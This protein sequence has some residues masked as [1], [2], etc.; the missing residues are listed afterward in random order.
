ADA[1]VRVQDFAERTQWPAAAGQHRIE[2][3]VAGGQRADRRDAGP[4]PQARVEQQR[5]QGPAHAHAA[6]DEPGVA[7]IGAGAGPLKPPVRSRPTARPSITSSWRD[8]S[9]RI[10]AKSGFAGSR[11][12][13]SPLRSKRLTVTSS[14]R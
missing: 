5:L 1:G 13:T 12:T 2:R 9:T 14:P 10:G 4:A 11:R 6:A 8:R 3:G 7:R